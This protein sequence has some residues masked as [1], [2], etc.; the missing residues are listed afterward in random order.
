LE[1]KTDFSFFTFIENSTILKK[2][3]IYCGSNKGKNPVYEEGAKDLANEMVKRNLA[4]V[5]GAGNVGLMGVIADAML[6]AGMEVYGIIPQ[7]LGYRSCPQGID[8][9]D[10]RRNH[11]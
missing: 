5:Y 2:I 6:E 8:R 11:A 4:L 1:I 3:T 9:I 7:K 10:C